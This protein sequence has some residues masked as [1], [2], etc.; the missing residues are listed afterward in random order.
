MSRLYYAV[1]HVASA[2]LLVV[3]V[4]ATSHRAAQ[5]LVG[6]H[7]AKPGR[8]PSTTTRSI[9]ELFAL[10]NQADYNRLFDVSPELAQ[11]HRQQ[12]G[13]VVAVLN[14]VV[15]DAGHAGIQVRR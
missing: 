9:A 8:V 6:L 2:A 7:L 15:V 5:S 12:A 4:E 3:G 13:E 11:F 1:F 10:R 14:L